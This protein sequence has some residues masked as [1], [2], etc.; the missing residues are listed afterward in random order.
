MLD[1]PDL[2]SLDDEVESDDELFD[3]DELSDD[4][5][6]DD[7][8]SEDD[9]ESAFSAPFVFLDFDLVPERASFR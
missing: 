1:E 8:L 2:V 6:S 5:L 3:D 9:D 7:E 4:E